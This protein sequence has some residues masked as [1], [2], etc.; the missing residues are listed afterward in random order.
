MVII[1]RND[2]CELS[3]EEFL[4]II[5]FHGEQIKYYLEKEI[6][7]FIAFY[8]VKGIECNAIFDNDLERIINTAMESFDSFQFRDNIDKEIIKKLLK[9]QYNLKVI[10]DYPLNIQQIKK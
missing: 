4:N 6:Y 7:D 3:D 10:K 9:N 5:K 1:M 2:F 8:I